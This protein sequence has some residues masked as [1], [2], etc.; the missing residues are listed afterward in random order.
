MRKIAHGLVWFNSIN[1]QKIL[2]LMMLQCSAIRSAYQ[3]VHKGHLN[4][5][6]V[7]IQVRQY[8]RNELNTRYISDA[9]I[10]A[11][12]ISHDKSIF[13]GKK[14]WNDLIKGKITKQEWNDNRNN[15]LYSRGD[16]IKKGN[17]NIRI[18]D[19]KLLINDPS[20]RGLWIEGNL[21]IPKK[22]KLNL[23]CYDIRIIRRNN[24]FEVKIGWEEKQQ[25]IQTKSNNG[26]IGLDVNLDGVAFVEADKN[27]NLLKHKYNRSQRI[28]FAKEDKRNH[29]IRLLAKDI[30]E[31]S[32]QINKPI[33]IEKLEFKKK[34]KKWKK[35]N[36]IIHNF[37]Y[38][39][40]LESIKLRACKEKVEIIEI[41]P[42]FTSILGQ[43]KYQKMYSLNRHTSAALV[44]ARRG[45][46]L[47]ERKNF[48]VMPCVEKKDALNLDGRGVSIALSNKAYSWLENYF[49][50]PKSAILTGSELVVG[51]RP[52]ISSSIGENPISE[53]NSITG[54]IGDSEKLLM[55]DGK[56]PW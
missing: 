10:L 38:K 26:M 55:V 4:D 13:G 23:D 37:L 46:N 34:Q 18:V 15:Q 35:F 48:T 52:T 42:A 29:D 44:I 49:L 54:R 47:K 17:P 56:T 31:T 32:K 12:G 3:T 24:K 2:K 19:N 50:K 33:V 40:M 9:C 14:S 1:E 20:K 43:L 11:S 21:F 28:Q 41:N 36:R 7:R 45:M 6:D 16:K 53:T 25:T 22:T 39:K 5:N 30:V 8:Y 51:S 27:G